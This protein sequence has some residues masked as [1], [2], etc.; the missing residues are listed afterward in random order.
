MWAGRRGR[1]GERDGGGGLISSH[2]AMH[3]WKGMCVSIGAICFVGERW[4][5]KGHLVKGIRIKG[6]VTASST[7]YHPRY[8]PFEF[9]SP[10]LH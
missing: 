9:L 7:R 4:V 8:H 3:R 2:G 10:T 1:A 6:V 5:S